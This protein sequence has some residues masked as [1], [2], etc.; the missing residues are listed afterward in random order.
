[1]FKRPLLVG[2]VFVFGWETVVMALPGYLK[3]FTVA[4]YLQG[5]VPHAMPVNSPMSIIEALFRETPPLTLCLFWLVTIT[6]VALYLAGRAV[7]NREY[8]LEQ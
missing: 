7:T 4:Y 6:V 8:V 2:L 1:M 5:L 3:R